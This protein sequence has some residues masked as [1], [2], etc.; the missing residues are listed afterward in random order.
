MMNKFR[1]V[2]LGVILGLVLVG[3]G[4]LSLTKFSS[5]AQ[6]KGQFQP[7]PITISDGTFALGDWSTKV[8]ESTGGS[9]HSVRQEIHNGVLGFDDEFRAMTHTLPQPSGAD[10][11]RISVAHLYLGASY[12]PSLQGAID[13]LD[14]QQSAKLLSLPWPDAVVD[15]QVVVTQGGQLFISTNFTRIFGTTD[16]TSGSLNNLTVTNFTASDGSGAHPDFSASGGEIRF[17]Y[18]RTHSRLATLPPVPPGD[19][20]IEHGIDSWRVTIWPFQTAPGNRPP[21]AVN[22]EF[23]VDADDGDPARLFLVAND[24]DPDG[25]AIYITEVITTGTRGYV[26]PIGSGFPTYV[27]YEPRFNAEPDS[28]DY[29]I[30]DGELTASAQVQIYV[31]CFCVFNCFNLSRPLASAA[32]AVDLSLIR[33]LRDQVMKP[34]PDG[35]RYVQ[36]YYTTTPEIARVLM[37]THPNLGQA[38]VAL[39]ELWQDNLASLVDGDGSAVVT[40]P[41]VEAIEAFLANL[42]AAGSADLQQLIAAELTRLGPLDEYVGLTV[43]EAKSQAIGDAV[44]YLPLIIK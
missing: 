19:L 21:I 35:N 6:A 11:N 24:S 26:G 23:V 30:T 8:V 17:G 37:V 16:W 3:I 15:T 32:S 5:P 27:L 1:I 2:W 12:T 38:A 39:V 7:S 13:R 36:M 4:W 44:V 10:I 20:V 42:S 40:Q 41:Q 22:D 31:D 9:S 18:L 14:Y 43:K 33:R 29:T 25:N 34:T 28:F